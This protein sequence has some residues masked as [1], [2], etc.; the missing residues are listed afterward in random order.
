[1][2]ASVTEVRAPVAAGGNDWRRQLPALLPGLVAVG[3]M[4][5]WA[6]HDGGYDAD[7]WYWGAL[8][9]L[10]VLVVA[11]QAPFRR[12]LSGPTRVA[13]GAFSLYVAWSYLSM[14]W[15]DA[16]GTALDG[17]NRALLYLI[18]FVVLAILPWRRLGA[19]LAVSAFTFGVG[20]IGF[21]ILIRLASDSHVGALIIGGRLSAPTGYFNATAALFTIG[22]LCAIGLGARRE[23]PAPLRGI[24]IACACAGLQ[25]AL[26]AQ[27]RGWLFTLPVVLVLAL[28]VVPDRLRFV[29]ASLL[30]AVAVILPV[31]R[32]LS[33]FNS[34]TSALLDHA[35]RTAGHTALELCFA[36]FVLG[37]LWAWSERFVPLEIRSAARRRQVGIVLIVLALGGAAAGA[38]AATHG[39]PGRFLQK[40]WRGLTHPTVAPASGSHFATIGSGRYDFWRVAF[41]AVI[42]HPLGGLGQDNFAEYYLPRR[43]TSQEPMWTH[44]LELRLLAHTGFVGFALFLAFLIAAVQAALRARRTGPPGTRAVSA[45]CVLPLIVW[46]VHGSVDWFWEI[47]ALAAPALGFLAVGGALAPAEERSALA[48][49]LPS[50]RVRIPRAVALLAGGIAVLAAAVALGFSYLSVREVSLASDASAGQTRAALHDYTL[51]GQLNP[52]NAEAGQLGGAL[53]LERHRPA[54]AQGFFA[55]SLDRDPR[56]WFSWLGAGLAASAVGERGRAHHDFVVAHS[57]NARQPPVRAALARVYSRHPLT[58]S[59]ALQLITVTR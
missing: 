40:Q 48:R 34:S 16:P 28:V 47:P 2:P 30:P 4:L 53:A 41:D 36:M 1:M 31:R 23:L 49:S 58:Y 8:L 56:A 44:S 50:A 39:D 43:H 3:L 19:L 26:M 10:A 37:T 25:L 24:F 32:L 7:T 29:A 22:A 17:S 18:V 12:R 51:A 21:V 33:V 54:A 15:A 5:V 20:V 35:A 46:V 45:I 14:A 38:A 11:L 55:Q 52:F 59:E 27:S 9:A 6:A 42:A 13:V 57:I